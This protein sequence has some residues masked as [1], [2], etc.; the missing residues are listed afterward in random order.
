MRRSFSETASPPNPGRSRPHSLPPMD[1]AN[2][3][4]SPNLKNI[5]D[6]DWIVGLT[7]LHENSI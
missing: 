3:N 7:E 6:V 1:I 5:P 2:E 4:S